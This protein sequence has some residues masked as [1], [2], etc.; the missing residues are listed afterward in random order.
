MNIN[1]LIP[2]QSLRP[3]IKTYIVVESQG[4]EVN[5]VVPDTSLVMSFRYKG[6]VNVVSGESKKNVLPSSAFSGLRKTVRMFNYS[7]DTGNILVLF[8]EA[9]AAAFFKEPLNELFEGIDSLDN[10]I[11]HQNFSILEEQL[12]E[13]A[14]NV[15]RISLIED[16]LLSKLY[17]HKPDELIS[18]ALQKIHWANGVIKIKDLANILNISQ[19][20]FEKRFRRVVGTSPKHFSSIIR[21]ESIVRSREQNHKLADIVFKAGYFDQPHF[22]KEF[23]LFTGQTPTDFFKAPSFLQISDFLQ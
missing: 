20:P 5:R 14:D 11:S 3:F 2:T 13:A 10:F 1:A 8:K 16:F 7:K 15:Q 6:Q 4:E 19:D 17:D 23:K 9:R 22:N 12:A 18:A 21:M